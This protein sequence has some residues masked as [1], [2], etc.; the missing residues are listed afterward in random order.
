MTR[1]ELKDRFGNYMR[2]LAARRSFDLTI[3]GFQSPHTTLFRGYMQSRSRRR[4]EAKMGLLSLI[5]GGAGLGWT[6]GHEAHDGTE[7][8]ARH[9]FLPR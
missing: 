5:V 2:M 3:A 9:G 8:W 1:T 4:L 7:D 6:W